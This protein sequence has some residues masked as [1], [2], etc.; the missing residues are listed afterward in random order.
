VAVLAREGLDL[1]RSGQ[2]VARFRPVDRDP[3]VL[4]RA[5]FGRSAGIRPF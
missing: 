3:A 1:G 2:G 4:E 5:R